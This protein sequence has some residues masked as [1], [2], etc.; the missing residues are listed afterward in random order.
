MLSARP[1]S[2][3]W[4][5]IGRPSVLPDR[6]CESVACGCSGG[7]AGV[8]RHLETMLPVPAVCLPRLVAPP[9]WK[10]REGRRPGLG[11]SQWA[12]ERPKHHGWGRDDGFVFPHLTCM[13]E[14]HAQARTRP[15]RECD[16]NLAC[17]GGW[18]PGKDGKEGE[19]NP[20]LR[21]GAEGDGIDR[22]SRY[23]AAIGI[24]Q[25]CR[26]VHLAAPFPTCPQ[27]CR[28]RERLWWRPK[29]V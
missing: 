22:E 23:G 9:E 17:F 3:Y 6:A 28:R 25:Q 10:K 24:T 16:T 4:R 26:P 13:Y 11:S 1:S 12:W 20:R 15:R 5:W 21:M 8:T 7:C 27:M 29:G 2:L 18:W 14:V 19:C